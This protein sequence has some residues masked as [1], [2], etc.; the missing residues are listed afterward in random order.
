MSAALTPGHR[1]WGAGQGLRLCGLEIAG[2]V[3]VAIFFSCE[4]HVSEPCVYMCT[5]AQVCVRNLL[6]HSSSRES[7]GE[8]WR[9]EGASAEGG[10]KAS[11]DA[12]R[13]RA[14][15]MAATRADG[16]DFLTPRAQRQR[17]EPRCCDRPF[18][19]GLIQ[20]FFFFFKPCT[21]ASDVYGQQ[22]HL[23]TAV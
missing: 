16:H 4:K 15:I 12:P 2:S 23:R 5:H 8:R 22:Y 1:G 9:E 20:F 3:C 17:I 11:R 6:T 10:R 13:H 7:E 21:A 19:I 14:G 18:F